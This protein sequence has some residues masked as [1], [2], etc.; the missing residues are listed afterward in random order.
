MPAEIKKNSR[1][2][3][4]SRVN[5]ILEKLGIYSV[6]IILVVIGFA[7]FGNRFLSFN[8]FINM[9]DAITLLGIVSVGVSFVIYSGHFA[10]LSIPTVMAFSGII[11]VEFL[12]YGIVPAIISGLVVGLIIGVINGYVIGK[13]RANP[14]IWTLAMAY[15][16]KGLMRW[17]WLNKQIYPDVKGGETGAGH[18]FIQLYRATVFGNVSVSLLFMLILVVIGQ[19]VFK[20]TKYGQQLKI[21]G[22]N[23]EVAK[24]TGINVTR[25]AQSTYIISSL[26]AAVAGIFLASLGKVGAYYQGEGYDFRAITAVV[27]G[28]LSL[29]GGRGSVLGVLGGVLVIGL[30]GNIMTLMGIDTFS[31]SVVTGT[32]FIIVVGMNARSIRKLGRDDG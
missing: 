1:S 10:D 13:I 32:I 17:I 11:A 2:I 21:I 3:K 7:F 20:R 19:F 5:I 9:L 30:L 4:Q 8:N 22:S 29:A 12:K 24:M 27:I 23:F 31:Q 6:A 15:V 25:L 28:G 16:T 18:A 26:A 14:V